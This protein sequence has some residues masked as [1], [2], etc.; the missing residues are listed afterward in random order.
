[1]GVY[2]EMGVY[3]SIRYRYYISDELAI[4]LKQ[5]GMTHTRG[6]P[7]HAQTQG[8]IERWHRSLKN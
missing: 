5:N 4:Y 7:Y 1:M 6:K 2:A 8:K 3:A